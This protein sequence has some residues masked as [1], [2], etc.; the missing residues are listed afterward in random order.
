MSLGHAYTREPRG[1]RSELSQSERGLLGL[2][3]GKLTTSVTI[4]AAVSARLGD[5]TWC[6]LGVWV[7]TVECEESYGIYGRNMIL[8][9]GANAARRRLITPKKSHY[10]DRYL[11]HSKEE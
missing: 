3:R 2:E 7:T 10:L 9:V 1:I 8:P 5:D 4:T 6:K 11:Q